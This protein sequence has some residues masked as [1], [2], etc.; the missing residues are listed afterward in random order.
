MFANL[1]I[2]RKVTIVVLLA[3]LLALGLAAIGLATYEVATF[4]W[5]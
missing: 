4:W 5:Q 2:R 3:S 1:S